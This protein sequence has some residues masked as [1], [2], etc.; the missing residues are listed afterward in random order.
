M[1]T[2]RRE[3]SHSGKPQAMFSLPTLE[4]VAGFDNQNT[5]FSTQNK[6]RDSTSVWVS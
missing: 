3:I 4:D 2:L 5:S 1:K 6:I